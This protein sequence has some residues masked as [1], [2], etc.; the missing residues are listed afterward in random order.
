LQ[1]RYYDSNICR[2]INADDCRIAQDS[3]EEIIELNIFTY[4]GNNSINHCDYDGHKRS[5]VSF[6]NIY[7]FYDPD[8]FSHQAKDQQK[9]SKRQYRY[10]I[11]RI[12]SVI[13]KRQFI[14]YWNEYL[15]PN[16]I[17]Y[18]I[19]HGGPFHIRTT[20]DNFLIS[21][22]RKLSNFSIDKLYI[23]A[24]NCAHKDVK[25][26]IANKIKSKL[27]RAKKIYAMDGSISYYYYPKKYI[28][29][30]P[31]LSFDQNGYYKYASDITRKNRYG[32][33]IRY[34]RTP[35]GLYRV[36]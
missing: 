28:G 5:I 23:Y 27:T 36:K 21:D 14:Y 25:N 31:R 16:C 15:K 32:V 10:S 22:V 19:F 35:T 12:I 9:A 4:C 8:D 30:R 3:K 20:S 26:N 2:F 7:I 17:I 18:L 11:V 24:C 33:L 29:Y 13:N 1:S 34:K 6:K